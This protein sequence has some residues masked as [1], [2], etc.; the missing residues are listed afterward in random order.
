MTEYGYVDPR[1]IFSEGSLQKIRT[2]KPKEILRSI[3]EAQK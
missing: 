2:R 3:K 1:S